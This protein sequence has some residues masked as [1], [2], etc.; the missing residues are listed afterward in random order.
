MMRVEAIIPP[1]RL[2]RLRAAL[3]EKGFVHSTAGRPIV[4]R[5]EDPSV[6]Y[7]WIKERLDETFAK[8]EFLHEVVREKGSIG[9]IPA[10]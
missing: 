7:G 3:E 1:D 9:G 6:I 2:E 10:T 8:L 5:P 4:Y